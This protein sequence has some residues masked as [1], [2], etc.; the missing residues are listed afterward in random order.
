MAKTL[1]EV[2]TEQGVSLIPSS[3]GRMVAHCPFHEGD[4][5]PSFTVYETGT[6]FCFGCKTWG[7]AYKFLLDR[8]W[9]PRDAM[10]YLGEDYKIANKEKPTIIK[11]R[12]YTEAYQLLNS[13]TEDYHQ[14]LLQSRGALQYVLDRGLTLE[15]IKKFRIGYTDGFT[16]R[17][18]WA[19]E[20]ALA[21][22][23]GLT[24]RS[25]QEMLAHRITIPNQ[26]GNLVDFIVGRSVSIYEKVKYL[27][28]RLPKPLYGLYDVRHS[29]VIFIVEGQFDWLTLRQWGYPA[30]AVGGVH[31]NS[32]SLLALREK[33]LIIIP[34]NDDTGASMAR[35]FRDQFPNSITIDYS[36]L[37][38]KDV[39]EL[40]IKDGGREAFDTVVKEQVEWITNISEKAWNQY[41]QNSTLV[42]ASL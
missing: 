27:G 3:A 35:S 28:I 41:F 8:G 12:S 33:K 42:R 15:T 21:A 31:A 14:F 9:S 36:R 10:S 34:D 2:L 22:K 11:V 19:E 1:I 37:G 25:G 20:A 18:S 29:G 24:S 7:D 5:S 16:L 23:I 30:V 39:S 4:E 40:A 6:Y 13:A 17:I 38:A 26:F 32:Q